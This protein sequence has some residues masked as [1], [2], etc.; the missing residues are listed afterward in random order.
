MSQ[1]GTVKFFDSTKGFGFIAADN[2]DVA[3]DHYHRF[4]DDVA[5]MKDL[6]LD[7]YR[8][9]V[10][11]SRVRPDG[12]PLNRKGLDFYERLVDELRAADILPWLTLY[13][14]DM[15]Q[16]IE[17]QG[18]WTVRSTSEQF[19][20]YALSVHD[21]LGNALLD[22]L[23][24]ALRSGVVLLLSHEFLSS[25]YFF[26]ETPALRGPLRVRALVRVR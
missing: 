7:T 14:W 25:G 8:F 24:N 9:S 5:L 15:P 21:A 23:A 13:H 20:E 1:I 4:R 26:S 6:G 2:G 22:L 19:V 16:A 12:G 3:C 11:W 18:G 17:E 10:S